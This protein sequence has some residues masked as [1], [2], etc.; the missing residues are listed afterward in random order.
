MMIEPRALAYIA[1]LFVGDKL[2]VEK[3]QLTLLRLGDGCRS[4]ADV[5]VHL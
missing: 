2:L 5:S 1:M 3:R 4:L